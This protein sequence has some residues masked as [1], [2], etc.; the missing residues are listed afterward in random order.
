MKLSTKI[1]G[2]LCVSGALACSAEKDG[3]YADLPATIK[4]RVLDEESNPINHIKVS[5]DWGENSTQTTVYTSIRGEFIVEPEYTGDGFSIILE[6]IDGED[7]GGQFQT[8]TDQ[9]IIFEDLIPDDQNSIYL[10]YR[11]TRATSSVNS[12]QSL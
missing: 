2:L 6:D 12:L 9:I 5:F 4:G 11:L 10:E 3:Y 1:V 8:L 7:N